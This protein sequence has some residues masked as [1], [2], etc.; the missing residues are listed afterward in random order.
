MLCATPAADIAYAN[1][2]SLY[3]VQNESQKIIK[4]N[5]RLSTSANSI[6]MNRQID[7]RH[8]NARAHTLVLLVCRSDRTRGRVQTEEE[9]KT[10]ERQQHI[11]SDART[12]GIVSSSTNNQRA[13]IFRFWL[14]RRASSNSI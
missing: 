2:L 11:N 8:D 5:R 7:S 3:P 10:D 6:R 9:Y 4:R 1:A 13:I 12:A 14:K